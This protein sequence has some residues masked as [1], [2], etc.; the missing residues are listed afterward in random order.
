MFF[1]YFALSISLHINKT[2][3]QQLQL[4]EKDDFLQEA[5]QHG[6]IDERINK[7]NGLG[8]LLAE[9]C[10]EHSEPVLLSINS[11][12][13]TFLFRKNATL[14][15]FRK[16]ELLNCFFIENQKSNKDSSKELISDIR[17]ATIHSAMIDPLGRRFAVASARQISVYSFKSEGNEIRLEAV[18]D[19]IESRVQSMEFHPNGDTILFGASDGQIYNWYFRESIT[20]DDE[21]YQSMLKAHNRTLERYYGHSAVVSSVAF[22]P[23]AKSFF[24]ADWNGVLSIWRPFRDDS[25][26]GEYDQNKT[27]KNF[28]TDTTKRVVAERASTEEIIKIKVSLDGELLLLATTDGMI[29]GWKIR[30]FKKNFGITAHKGVIFDLAIS[31]TSDVN[32]DQKVAT[33]G[34][35]G[36]VRE[37][38]V[39]PSATIKD[40]FDL[41]M[42]KEFKADNPRKVAFNSSGEV[43]IVNVD[44]EILETVT[45]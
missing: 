12:D 43:V 38:K 33:V 7:N 27:S 9:N 32:K 21:I 20:E 17:S 37:W 8:D 30:G 4:K 34:R 40:G 19:G 18:L 36:F 15:I 39:V 5:E 26:L 24:S 2:N 1:A 44:G 23:Y 35:D 31:N 6:A 22:H 14:K 3:A 13:L 10:Q 11:K 16:N 45:E 25:A 41:Q 29:E 28:Y 42:T